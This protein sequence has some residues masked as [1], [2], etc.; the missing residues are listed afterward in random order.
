MSRTR[1]LV[2][3]LA[4]PIIGVLPGPPLNAVEPKTNPQ[5]TT[6]LI[7]VDHYTALLDVLVPG[8]VVFAFA[9]RDRDPSERPETPPPKG[10]FRKTI[11]NDRKF[12]ESLKV[13]EAVQDLRVEKMIVLSS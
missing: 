1:S 9:V 5:T 2:L 11:W 8:D 10:Q 7:K 13:L 4:L 6:T 12:S 3:A